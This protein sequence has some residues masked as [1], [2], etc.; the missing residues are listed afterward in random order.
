VT[1][2]TVPDMTDTEVVEAR[3]CCNYREALDRPC[4]GTQRFYTGDIQAACDECGGWCGVD[5]PCRARSVPS[6]P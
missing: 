4:H 6:P 5:A 2:G 3:P 1:L